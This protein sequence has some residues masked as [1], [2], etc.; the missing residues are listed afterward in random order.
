MSFLSWLSEQEN[1]VEVTHQFLR[2]LGVPATS[3]SLSQDLRDH[4]D[5]PSLLSISDVLSSYKMETL[6]I[7]ASSYDLQELPVP[8][9]TLIRGNMRKNKSYTVVRNVDA[10]FLVY[11]NPFKKDW[12][13]TA[14]KDF[15]ESW[16]GI[17]LL[18]IAPHNTGAET[19]K[20][21]PLKEWR[22]KGIIA[23]FISIIALSLGSFIMKVLQNGAIQGSQRIGFLLLLSLQI[24][25]IFVTA[26]LLW[27]EIDKTN[28]ILLRVCTGGPKTNCNSILSSRHSKLFNWLSWSE[29]GFIY[30]T[31]GFVFLVQD[32]SDVLPKLVLL[33]W[34]NVLTLPYSIYS[35]YYQGRI[36]RQWCRLCLA[37][38]AILIAGVINSLFTGIPG[39]PGLSFNSVVRMLFS[40]LFPAFGWWVIKP[41][42]SKI[43]ESKSNKK[44]YLR[45]KFNPQ[46]FDIILK[47]QKKPTMPADELGIILGN[48]DAKHT[49][50]AVSNPYCAPCSKA[51]SKI[52]N[53]LHTNPNVKVRILFTTSNKKKEHLKLPVKH[54]LAIQDQ[55]E[56]K[57]MLE[58]LDDWYLAK[59]KNYEA[60]AGKYP[61]NG[62]LKE[63]DDKINTMENW[64]KE[65]NITFT[66]TIFID[67]YQMP[68]IY[69]IEDINYFLSE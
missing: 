66:P 59:N 46:I 7:K 29:I 54:L 60:F 32:A 67:G 37:V 13:T 10:E 51:H 42:F 49:I 1:C 65:T 21:T 38:Q 25:G 22:S 58:A 35:I 64:C 4:P 30:F 33:S 3:T 40:F 27:Y 14:I 34:L 17:A 61:M 48:A 55:R 23:G 69:G 53:I 52:E 57:L 63:Q 68:D 8:F 31:G 6:S 62:E 24:A 36:A 44:N 19:I 12:E 26:L 50:L 9:I 2:T 5:Y 16:D 11:Y 20:G 15:K 39:Y 18:A 41:Y 28:P 43:L 47:N 45:L 56:E